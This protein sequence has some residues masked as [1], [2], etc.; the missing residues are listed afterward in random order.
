MSVSCDVYK[1][2]LCSSDEYIKSGI[3]LLLNQE[4]YINISNNPLNC[5]LEEHTLKIFLEIEYEHSTE[6][7]I[8]Y[9]SKN[10]IGKNWYRF[11]IWEIGL[12]RN[13]LEEL[14]NIK[15]VNQINWLNFST[16]QPTNKKPAPLQKFHNIGSEVMKRSKQNFFR[17]MLQI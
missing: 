14:N 9:L 15:I 11:N 10:N 16:I 5:V 8:E 4:D 6:N 2:Y 3:I 13:K 12:L 1:L 17:S 7:I